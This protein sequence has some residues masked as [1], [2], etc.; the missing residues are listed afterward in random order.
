[1]KT[2]LDPSYFPRQ[3]NMCTTDVAS[4]VQEQLV[5]RIHSLSSL[6]LPG[7]SILGVG[8]WLEG[9]CLH[10][11]GSAI[12]LK[13]YNKFLPLEVKKALAIKNAILVIAFQTAQH[14]RYLG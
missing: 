5:G 9:N 2:E 14:L 13:I 4:V 1:M 6:P 11:N 10:A 8:V 12:H 3:R 7:H